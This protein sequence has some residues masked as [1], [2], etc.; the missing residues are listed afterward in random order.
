M[1]TEDFNNTSIV[2]SAVYNNILDNLNPSFLT[3]CGVVHPVSDYSDTATCSC[4]E[5]ESDPAT[6]PDYC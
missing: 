5:T 4:I 1:T 3:Y 2:S 6:C